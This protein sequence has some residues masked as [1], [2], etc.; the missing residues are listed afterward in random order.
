MAFGHQATEDFWNRLETNDPSLVH[1]WAGRL[2]FE[3]GY[4][5]QLEIADLLSDAGNARAGWKVATINKVLQEQ[6][7]TD[8]PFF[9]SLRQKAVYKTGY[10]LPFSKYIEPHVETEICFRVADGIETAQTAED[11]RKAIDYCYPA[12]ELIEK[13]LPV[14]GLGVGL[15]DNAEHKAIV[16]GA[17]VAVTPELTFNRETASLHI[18]GRQMGVGSGSQI[19]GDPIN[20]IL[21]L[22]NKLREFGRSLRPGEFVMTGSLIRQFPLHPGDTVSA[23]FSTIGDV[24]IR[25]TE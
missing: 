6:L 21:W 20:S 1:K 22:N 24:A 7:G 10:E 12:F 16:L 14:R 11:I 2:S 25:V 13:R 17:P 5:I 8:Q 19:L 4:N 3:E 15:A 23:K 18:N 9:G